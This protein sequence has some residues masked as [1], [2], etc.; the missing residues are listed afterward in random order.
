M[1]ATR[2]LLAILPFLFTLTAGCSSDSNDGSPSSTNPQETVGTGDCA[3]FPADNP[4]NTDISSLSVHANSTNFINSIG[5]D[6]GIHPDFGTMYAGEPNGFQYAVVPQ[7]QTLVPISFDY[8]DE[9]DPGPYP[10]PDNVP[11]EGGSDAHIIVIQQ[12]VCKLWE[13]WQASK[14]SSGWHGGSGALFDL[15]SN[16]LR[17]DGWTS[18]DAAGLPIFPGLVRYEEVEA[19][20]IPHALRITVENT[21][22]GYIHP[23]THFASDSTDSNLP[24]MG[25]RVR[26]KSSVDLSGFTPRIQVILTALKKYGAF[27]ADNGSNWY[28]SGVYNP[29]W[30]DD[31]L[32]QLSQQIQGSD[33]EAVDTGPIL[34]P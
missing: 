13:V 5:A 28:L 11:I 27:V 31:E 26:L 4:W 23:A 29:A 25:L 19:G 2:T 17:P 9:S 21:Q 7:D 6:T 32:R 33:F 14:V 30:D 15:N 34:P 20:E 22:K 24:P 8:A 10:I 12:G 16:A 18:A 3:I 1:G